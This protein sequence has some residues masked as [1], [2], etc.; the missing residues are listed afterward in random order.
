[1]GGQFTLSCHKEFLEANQEAGVKLALSV[2]HTM[3]GFAYYELEDFDN[4]WGRFE[5][6]QAIAE[7]T[8]HRWRLAEAL[9]GFGLVH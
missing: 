6:A 3:V 8:G 4:A 5:A 7:E 1:L 9:L 2:A